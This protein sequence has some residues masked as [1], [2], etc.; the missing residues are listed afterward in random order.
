[1]RFRCLV[2]FFFLF[3]TTIRVLLFVRRVIVNP[4]GHLF[5][6]IIYKRIRTRRRCKTTCQKPLSSSLVYSCNNAPYFTRRNHVQQQVFGAR[7]RWIY[8]D[9]DNVYAKKKKKKNHGENSYKTRMVTI[10]AR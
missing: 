6:R 9:A 3:T 1:M 10:I 4:R 8:C 5:H 2:F 7:R